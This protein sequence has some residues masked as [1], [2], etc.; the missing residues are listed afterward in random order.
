MPFMIANTATGP[1]AYYVDPATNRTDGVLLYTQQQVV[2]YYN[3]HNV[4]GKL[5]LTR[6]P[7]PGE[8]M[9]PG[10]NLFPVGMTVEQVNPG[11]SSEAGQV[12]RT[13]R[14]GD[15]GQ[16]NGDPY[17]TPGTIGNPAGQTAPAPGADGGAGTGGGA[18]AGDPVADG[19]ADQ[20]GTIDDAIADL[21]R[22]T[23]VETPGAAQIGTTQG[24]TA[25]TVGG[26]VAT[27]TA[28]R[29]GG[30]VAA[31]TAAQASMAGIGGGGVSVP[32]VTLARPETVEAFL[33]DRSALG[34]RQVSLIDYLENIAR[35]GEESALTEQVRRETA[36]QEASQMSLAASASPAARA[37]AMRVGMQNI[38]RIQ[39]A[40]A[41]EV[42]TRNLA[43]KTEA[44]GLLS[45]LLGTARGQDIQE[46][47]REMEAINAARSLNA[48]L[49]TRTNIAQG[50]IEGQL[51]A[52]GIG[53]QA[54]LGAA[55]IG[56]SADIA[57]ANL[58]A[59]MQARMFA[60]EAAENRAMKEAEYEQAVRMFGAESA[61]ARALAEAGFA[62]EADIERF[63]QGS[64]DNRSQAE[65]EQQA[66]Q[67]G[68]DLQYRYRTADDQQLINL[69]G[70]STDLLGLLSQGQLAR[71]Q[72]SSQQLMQIQALASAW[73]IANL[74][75]ATQ[76]KLGKMSEPGF[77]DR[78]TAIAGP[79]LGIAAR[80]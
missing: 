44:R 26:T 70:Q 75:S 72:L 25:T 35:G 23:S 48:E 39:G 53:A 47:G 34:G 24:P 76:I 27:P 61:E 42:A 33:A 60:A 62:H 45:G 2:D 12:A 8:G 77:W 6:V 40:G 78:L 49:G 55:Q 52:A 80:M 28:A 38:G 13:W 64:A 3:S 9:P 32:K 36:A 66:G 43:A 69:I 29:V 19:I 67:F 68:A 14:I 58:D 59:E 54:T 7:A 4:D 63:R 20:Q 17:A 10:Y 21:K 16:T 5:R 50:Q 79:L 65:L 31:P 15:T 51:G 57:R 73:D 46:S 22:R 74:N 11:S 37:A 18:A 71:E 30:S 1:A 41:S 56:A